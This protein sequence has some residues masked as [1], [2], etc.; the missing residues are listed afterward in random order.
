MPFQKGN[1]LGNRKGRPKKGESLAELIR[2]EGG[3]EGR[4]RM[5]RRMWALASDPHDRPDLA[6][7]AAD[8][9]ADRGW[10]NE[11]SADITVTV[12]AYAWDLE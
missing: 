3:K 7:K 10:P 8:W 12:R 11:Q 2:S 4:Q 5:V 6:I 1:Q 9:I